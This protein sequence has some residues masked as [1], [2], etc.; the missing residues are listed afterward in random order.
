MTHMEIQKTLMEGKISARKKAL[1][2]LIKQ[3]INDPNFPRMPMVVLQYVQI[4][5]DHGLKKLCFLYWEV[6]GAISYKEDS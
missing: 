1:K 3:I 2:S 6:S 5:E 4:L